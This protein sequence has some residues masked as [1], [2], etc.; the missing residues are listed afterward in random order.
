MADTYSPMAFDA[1]RE[2]LAAA[3]EKTKALKAQAEEAA[4][5]ERFW[6]DLLGFLT[7]GW[8]LHFLHK[9][10]QECRLLEDLRA[11]GHTA[12]AAIEEARRTAEEEADKVQRRFPR[13]LE[14]AC[15]AAGISLD[16]DSPHPRYTIE[17]RFFKLEIDDHKRMARLSDTESRLADIPCDVGAIVELI[18]R[19]HKRVFGRSFDAKRFLKS[20]WSQ[21][22]AI[23]KHEKMSPKASV[24]IRKITRRLGKNTKGFRTDEF[25]VDLSRLVEAGFA[26]ID[27]WRLDLQQTKNTSDGI[28]L[29][30][31]AG[32]GYVGYVVFNRCNDGSTQDR[33]AGG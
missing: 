28:L 4:R 1:V 18:Q 8:P 12:V 27:G 29:H 19:E 24:P 26:E 5:A 32:R 31:I 9:L 15:R 30:G 10:N 11:A 20:L 17:R 23:L 3:K 13:F 7:R 6:G 22:T 21:Y 25:V 33:G 2:F 16:P 14:D